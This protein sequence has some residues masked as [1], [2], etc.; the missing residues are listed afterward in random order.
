MKKLS[1]AITTVATL[2]ILLG[3]LGIASAQGNVL[4]AGSPHYYGELGP[5]TAA[6][7]YSH[8][9]IIGYTD[10]W[11]DGTNLYVQYNTYNPWK[12]SETHLAVALNPADFPQTK[13]GNPQVGKF[14]YKHEGLNANTDFY[15]IPLSSLGLEAGDTV[16]IVA[17]AVVNSPCGQETSW[18]DCG[19]PDAY[20]RGNNWA[21]YFAYIVS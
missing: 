2:A 20:F 4:C 6:W 19:G 21:T 16:Y 14:P 17:H 11:N 9:S 12:I 5:K 3:S 8:V 13:S 10:T 18:A 7:Y 1:I 15:I